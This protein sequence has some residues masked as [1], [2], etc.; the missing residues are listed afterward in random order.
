[1]AA[2]FAPRWRSRIHI[3]STARCI[4]KV[5]SGGKGL[6][7]RLRRARFNFQASGQRERSTMVLAR[8]A[9]A[10]VRLLRDRSQPTGG[11]HVVRCV[12]ALTVARKTR[13]CRRSSASRSARALRLRRGGPEHEA[14]A[15]QVNGTRSVRSGNARVRR[16]PPS[17]RSCRHRHG[18]S[19]S[20]ERSARW[21]RQSRS[22]CVVVKA[23][24]M[25]Y[26]CIQP[27]QC[28]WLSARHPPARRATRPTSSRLRQSPRRSPRAGH[29]PAK[30]TMHST[31]CPRP[32]R[33]ECGPHREPRAGV[34]V[35]ASRRS[36]AL[37]PGLQAI[38]SPPNASCA[39]S[40]RP[41]SPA[42]LSR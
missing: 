6:S 14:K 27:V 28:A 24:N 22:C 34:P 21:P 41:S 9:S 16:A 11:R 33:T 17:P 8:T 23:D 3:R 35:S 4:M 29:D 2:C 37:L 5:V 38:A 25:Q 20:T 18:E 26:T 13:A 39:A 10:P 36:T 15:I 31:R 1:M 19:S 40:R 32:S 12:I 42:A 30:S 7:R